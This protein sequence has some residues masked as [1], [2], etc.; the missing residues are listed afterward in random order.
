[1][2]FTWAVSVAILIWG[3]THRAMLVLGCRTNWAVIIVLFGR[4]D[5]VVIMILIGWTDRIAILVLIRLRADVAIVRSAW[6]I[7]SVGDVV[8][9]GTV[10]FVLFVRFAWW[11]ERTIWRN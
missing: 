4:T 6:C 8:I 2:R 11:A 3:R 10:T 1:M 9:G 7:I 5:R